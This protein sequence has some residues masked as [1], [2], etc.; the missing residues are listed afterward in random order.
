MTSC[1]DLPLQVQALFVIAAWQEQVVWRPFRERVDI[2]RLYGDGVTGP[3]AALLR[4]Q[5]G[6]HVPWH[7]HLG[8]EH[9]MVLAGAQ[10]DEHGCAQAGTLTI[11]RPGSC[12][13]VTSEH[14]CIV[15]VIYE[16]PVRFCTPRAPA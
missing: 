1:L 5:A 4:Y 9:V 11:N 2:H 10:S 13:S 6:G 16:P 8:Y 7:V 14:G 3:G 15:L 12:H